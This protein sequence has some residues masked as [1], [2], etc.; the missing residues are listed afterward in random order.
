MDEPGMGQDAAASALAQP[1]RWLAFRGAELLLTDAGTLPAGDAL[2][3]LGCL[4]LRTQS[5]GVPADAGAGAGLPCQAAELPADAEPPPGTRFTHLKRL[6]DVLPDNLRRLAAR[7]LELLEWDRAH[8]FCGACGSATVQPGDAKVRRCTNPACGREHY[9]RV[10]PVVIVAVERGDE[11]LLGRSYHFA[12]GFYSTLAG[13][14]DAG[15]SAEEAIHREIDEE[16]ALR[17]RNV[18]YFASQP[19]PFPH[20]LMLGFQAEYEAG[21]IVCAP[22]EIEHAG[23]FHVDA[24]PASLPSPST[25]AHWLLRDFCRRR[26]RPWPPQQGG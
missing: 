17:V 10:S 20:S 15:E 12:P 19:W 25:I 18:R 8:Q 2:S 7:A 14:V 11:I 16:V 13:F 24:L 9:P 4:P 21:D 22:D 3:A 26:G 23:F 5:L 6:N 1:L